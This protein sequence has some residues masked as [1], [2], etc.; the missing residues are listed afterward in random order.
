M[1]R[2]SGRTARSTARD[3][4]WL[5][6]RKPSGFVSG[7]LT[8]GKVAHVRI[9]PEQLWHFA[10]QETDGLDEL[11][12]SAA[13]S[14]GGRRN[15]KPAIQNRMPPTALRA[16]L[17]ALWHDV[18]IKMWMMAAASKVR[19]VIESA[20]STRRSPLATLILGAP[21]QYHHPRTQGAFLG[22]TADA[23]GCPFRLAGLT[24]NHGI[25]RRPA[26]LLPASLLH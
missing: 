21:R 24:T 17:R 10:L 6:A 9:K 11:N 19:S 25:S 14:L 26:R 15:G 22:P 8:S 2:C 7:G 13:A 18:G 23:H 12:A 5:V 16:R 3:L 1:R 4:K 20:K